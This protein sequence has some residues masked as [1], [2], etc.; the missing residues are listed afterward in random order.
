MKRKRKRK[1]SPSFDKDDV[2]DYDLERIEEYNE[3]ADKQNKDLQLAILNSL[4]AKQEKRKQEDMEIKNQLMDMD[5]NK[6]EELA[7]EWW[8]Q[9]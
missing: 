6:I 4:N 8:R 3:D 1:R 9:V 7:K 5:E 2:P